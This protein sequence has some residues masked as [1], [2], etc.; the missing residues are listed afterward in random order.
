MANLRAQ[1]MVELNQR[2]LQHIERMVVIQEAAGNLG[3]SL[4]LGALLWF[5]S[6]VHVSPLAPPLW[7][8][9]KPTGLFIFVVVALLV[10]HRRARKIAKICRQEYVN[11]MK[12]RLYPYG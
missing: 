1:G 3:V 9:V 2:Q 4:I 10:R 11:L 6:L 5:L 12:G 8:Y 7:S